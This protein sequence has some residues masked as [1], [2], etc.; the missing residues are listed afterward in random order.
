[1]VKNK[2]CLFYLVYLSLFSPKR[3]EKEEGMVGSF[4]DFKHPS[5]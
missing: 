5:I 3:I 2:V 1:M 4:G